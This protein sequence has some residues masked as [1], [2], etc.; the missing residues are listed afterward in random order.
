[1]SELGVSRAAIPRSKVRFI[2]F[3]SKYLKRTSREQPA[4][5]PGVYFSWLLGF[6]IAQYD[7]MHCVY[8]F[9]KDL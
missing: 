1:V 9:D 8:S 4:L 5:E 2:S 6:V 7:K 3:V